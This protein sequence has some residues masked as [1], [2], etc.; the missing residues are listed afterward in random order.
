VYYLAAHPDP[1]QR[2]YLNLYKL[3]EGPLYSFYTPY[4]LCH[5]EVPYSIARVVLFGDPVIQP[6]AGPTVEVVTVAKTDLATGTRLDGIGGF[7]TYGTAE[8]AAPARR[9]R[10]LPMGLSEGVTLRRSV[11]RDSL[12]TWDDVEIP[13]GRLVDRLRAEQDAM[14]PV[15]ADPEVAQ[16]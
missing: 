8:N 12:L 13:E 10:L 2:Q 1:K 11:T 7:H 5:F 4:H 9:E 6:L 16:V 3:G 15:P 14:F